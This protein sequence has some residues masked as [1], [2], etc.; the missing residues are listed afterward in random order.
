MKAYSLLRCCLSQFPWLYEWWHFTIF[1]LQIEQN[2]KRAMQIPI[3][4]LCVFQSSVTFTAMCW[5]WPVCRHLIDGV[6]SSS[7]TAVFLG[8]REGVCCSAH[9][10]C[11]SVYIS[12]SCDIVEVVDHIACMCFKMDKWSEIEILS[13]LNQLAKIGVMDHLYDKSCTIMRFCSSEENVWAGK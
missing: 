7:W 4:V 2:L 8:P 13:Y 9:V 6:A 1:K 10:L 11:K 5:R 12:H 3:H